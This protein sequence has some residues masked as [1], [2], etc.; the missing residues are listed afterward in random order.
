MQVEV[1]AQLE[2]CQTDSKQKDCRVAGKKHYTHS[3]GGPF[4]KYSTVKRRH[5]DDG[6]FEK[7]ANREGQA[8]E[9]AG[10][11]LP[12]TGHQYYFDQTCST[13]LAAK[14]HRFFLHCHFVYL[15]LRPKYPG[16]TAH[17]TRLGFTL[18]VAPEASV[19]SIESPATKVIN[20]MYTACSYCHDML[21]HSQRILLSY[22]QTCIGEVFRGERQLSAGHR[23]FSCWIAAACNLQK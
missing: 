16:I 2:K 19:T 13:V 20:D 9:D 12:P 1:E 7:S 3:F 14:K 11:V 17:A 8:G 15:Q 23:K 5:T 22:V 18:T 21:M 6:H 10:E 4:P